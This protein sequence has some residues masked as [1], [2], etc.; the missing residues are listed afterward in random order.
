MTTTS[1]RFCPAC[2]HNLEAEQPV[3][4]GPLA[5]DPRG[6]ATWRGRK[7]RLTCGQFLIFDSLAQAGGAIVA[8]DILAE[9]AGFGD[10]DDPLNVV[11]VLICRIRRA[12]RAAGVPPTIIR[13]I[14]GR[15]CALD[16]QMLRELGAG[17]DNR[18]LE[19]GIRRP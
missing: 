7:I 16:T 6:E 4:F 1:A 14:R 2:G 11:D 18:D 8:K 15:G 10:S 19:Q 9:R 12:L 17:N 5:V 13:T 3:A